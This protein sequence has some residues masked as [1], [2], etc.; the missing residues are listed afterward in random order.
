[1]NSNESI[2]L[3]V[4][5]DSRYRLSEGV[6]PA[7]GS[8]D[9][10][11]ATCLHRRYI[12]QVNKNDFPPRRYSDSARQ[13]FL[14]VIRRAVIEGAQRCVSDAAKRSGG[15]SLGGLSVRGRPCAQ[16]FGAFF[17]FVHRSRPLDGTSEPTA[18][19]RQR[20]LCGCCSCGCV[21]CWSSGAMAWSLLSQA[22]SISALNVPSFPAAREEI[23]ATPQCF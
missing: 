12:R 7:Q 17:L 8:Q 14:R 3:D 9:N 20:A 18:S 21:S 16:S 4:F 23:P 1:M 19:L 2:L 6:R 5:G 10:I 11:V 13:D 15:R 22:T